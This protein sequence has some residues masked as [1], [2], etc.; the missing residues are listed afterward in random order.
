MPVVNI[1]VRKLQRL[2][3]VEISLEELGEHLASLGLS[4]EETADDVLRVEYNP[5]RPDFSSVYGVAR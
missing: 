2:L 4:V 3:G 1:R 5:N